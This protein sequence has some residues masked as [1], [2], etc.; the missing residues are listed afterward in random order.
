MPNQNLRHR[1]ELATFD[2]LSDDIYLEVFEHVSSTIH[3]GTR[4]ARAQ[5]EPVDQLKN[6]LEHALQLERWAQEEQALQDTMKNLSAVNWK[7]RLMLAPQLFRKVTFC[8]AYTVEAIKPFLQVLE[9]S[10]KTTNMFQTCL[11]YEATVVW[12]RNKTDF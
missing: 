4:T 1:P 6:S 9:Q 11:R 3:E 5:R 8:G 2:M 7:F 12:F 10:S